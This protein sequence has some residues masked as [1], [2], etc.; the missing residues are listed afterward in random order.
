MVRLV[1]ARFGLPIS[2]FA[3]G[4]ISSIATKAP[5][6]R[7]LR[8]TGSTTA[9]AA[10][11]ILSTVATIIQMVVVLAATNTEVCGPLSFRLLCWRRS[12]FYGIASR[13]SSGGRIQGAWTSGDER[14]MHGR[15]CSR[16]SHGD[17]ARVK[18][19]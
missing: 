16:H 12:R 17:P 11:A 15:N 10:G 3:S 14:S 18:S 19:R 7:V 6:A 1:G 8:G 9:A 5:W 4:F 2:G 13:F